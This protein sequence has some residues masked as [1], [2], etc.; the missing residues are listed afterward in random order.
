MAELGQ[1][2]W[3]IKHS[4]AIEMLAEQKIYLL[5]LGILDWVYLKLEPGQKTRVSNFGLNFF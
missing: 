1:Q 2:Y 5:N 4:N 3:V